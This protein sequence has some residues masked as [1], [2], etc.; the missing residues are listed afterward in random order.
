MVRQNSATHHGRRCGGAPE[1]DNGGT[2][3]MATSVL[4]LRTLSQQ[5]QMGFK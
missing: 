4:P 5:L 1:M 2:L 3:N